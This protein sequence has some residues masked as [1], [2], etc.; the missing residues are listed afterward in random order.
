[1]NRAQLEHVIRAAAS[2]ADDPEV[3]VIGSQAILGRYPDAPPSLCVSE[4]VD[5]Y[6]RNHPDRSELVDGAIGELSAFHETFGYYAHGV[7][8]QTATLPSG[9]ESRLVR[10]EGPGTA[11]AVGLC[12][13]PHDL[14]IS[15]LIA[16]REKDLEYL[17]VAVS[18]GLLNRD[19]LQRLLPSTSLEPDQRGLALGRLE[20]LY[21]SAL[22]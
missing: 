17:G 19:T 20:R 7:G 14:A 13:D 11:G 3:V 12:L 18:A 6:P 22:K 9:W 15:K 21:I 2:I 1:V 5:L 4:D 10:V 16:G 8:P